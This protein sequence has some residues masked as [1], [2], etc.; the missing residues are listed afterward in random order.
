[1]SREMGKQMALERFLSYSRKNLALW[2]TSIS[3][4]SRMQSDGFIY[5]GVPGE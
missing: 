4:F 5:E 2:A 1:M 3:A